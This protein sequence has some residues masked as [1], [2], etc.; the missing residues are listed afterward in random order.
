[1]WEVVAARALPPA[2]A[3]AYAIAAGS[4]THTLYFTTLCDLHLVVFRAFKFS[5]NDEIKIESV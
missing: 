1:M 4:G 5:R 2:V 3:A